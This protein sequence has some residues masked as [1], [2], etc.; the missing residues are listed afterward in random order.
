MEELSPVEAAIA[1]IVSNTK[2]LIG[3]DLDSDS[4]A[5]LEA[6]ATHYYG[7]AQGMTGYD[8][9][10]SNLLNYVQDAVLKAWRK[11][12]AEEL[13]TSNALGVSEGYID[14][15]EKLRKHLRTKQNPL[16]SVI[17]AVSST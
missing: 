6:F 5:R 15:D 11:R 4:E 9:I 3:G 7:M 10:P 17:T 12:G 14:I 1:A 8:V 16:S 2:L 13:H